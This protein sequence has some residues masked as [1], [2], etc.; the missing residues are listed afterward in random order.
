MIIQIQPETKNKNTKTCEIDDTWLKK[1][2]FGEL[3]FIN[4]SLLQ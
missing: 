3:L 1:N 4:T 2:G